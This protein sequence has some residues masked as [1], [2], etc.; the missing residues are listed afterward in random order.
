MKNITYRPN[1]K[2]YI[3]RKQIH[4]TIITVYAKTQ[5]ECINKLNEKIKQLKLNFEKVPGN[6]T[7]PTLLTY[8]DKWYKQNKEPFIA[9]STKK[10]FK[11][12]KQKLEPLFNVK[13]NKLTKDCILSFL[14]SLSENRTK[15]KLTLQLKCM[16]ETAVK[17][18]LIKYNPFDTII[19][20]AKKRPPKPPF[21]YEEQKLIL[22]NLKGKE[23]EP[24][25]LLYL[26]TGLRKNELDFENIEKN[27][28]DNNILTAINLKG[29]DR[30]V[31]YKKIKL[32]AQMASLVKEKAEVFH[33]YTSRRLFDSF[34]EFLKSQNIKGSVLTCRH[35]F[36]T[37]CF[38]LG[39]DSL[40]ISREMGHTTS[41]ITKDN[42]IDIDYNLSKEKILKLYNNLYNLD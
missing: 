8:W 5:R 32:S 7:G 22:E 13:L 34:D 12:I 10:D 30:I 3:G 11:Y 42:Y 39:K 14:Y 36:A 9:D 28:D 33:K 26:T 24:I 4:K 18:R 6:S 35:T 16:L 41:S 23:I 2:R 37:N 1:E 20:K 25:I 15:E 31:R 21:T 29:R 40:I 27:I 17:E 38:Y 19:F